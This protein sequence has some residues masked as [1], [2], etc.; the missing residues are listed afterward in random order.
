MRL[1]SRNFTRFLALE[2]GQSHLLKYKRLEKDW[3]WGVWVRVCQ[4]FSSEHIA[5]EEYIKCLKR[6]IKHSAEY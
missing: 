1:K 2:I 4:Y 5:F 3:M 6:N